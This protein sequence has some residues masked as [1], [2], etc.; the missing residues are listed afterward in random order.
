MKT[1]QL[2]ISFIQKH[3]ELRL[4][5]YKCQAGVWTIGWGHTL[6]VKEGDTT[7]FSQ[8]TEYLKSDVGVCERLL[9]RLNLKLNQNQYDALVSFIFNVGVGSFN[10]STLLKKV[11]VN[12]NDPSIFDEFLRWNKVNAENDGID[13]DN[14]GLIDEKGEKKVSQGLINRH[15]EEA[16]LYFLT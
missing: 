11:R 1:S 5:A 4:K 12:P 16:K 15:T 2:G 10:M 13:N 9:N 7:T 6:G 3:E 8:A 14:D